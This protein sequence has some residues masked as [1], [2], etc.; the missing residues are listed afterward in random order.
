MTG[1]GVKLKIYD[2]NSADSWFQ[3]ALKMGESDELD[4]K[5]SEYVKNDKKETWADAV[6]SFVM[7]TN[8]S[9]EATL[10][11][12]DWNKDYRKCEKSDVDCG[13]ASVGTFNDDNVRKE[14]M[15]KINSD[16]DSN[17][18][19]GGGAPH[20]DSFADPMENPTKMPSHIPGTDDLGPNDDKTEANV[21]VDEP[22]WKIRQSKER[23]ASRA[24]RA[25]KEGKDS[26][27]GDATLTD[28]ERNEQRLNILEDHDSNMGGGDSPDHEDS[29]ADPMENPTKRPS[30]VPGSDDLGPDDDADVD[31]DANKDHDIDK[32]CDDGDANIGHDKHDE[33][34]RDKEAKRGDDGDSN[35][36]SDEPEWKIRQDEERAESRAKRA[37]KEGEAKD[38]G[39]GEP[40]W[41]IRQDEER[42]ESRAKRAEKGEDS[43]RPSAEPPTFAPHAPTTE[44]TY[45]PVSDVANFPVAAPVVKTSPTL[46]P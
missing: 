2:G 17:M 30:H 3:D 28:D 15:D 35:G 9:D 44:P 43:E 6:K 10:L 45:S 21:G 26:A 14:Q 41:K 13:G 20:R 25:A 24:K 7:F 1:A 34:A 36:S 38:D 12:A 37:E 29:F 16:E 46:E 22:A 39:G 23:A 31:A 11:A 32:P 5:Q 40:E 33:K 8:E 27:D 18:G 42:A 4:L 19:G